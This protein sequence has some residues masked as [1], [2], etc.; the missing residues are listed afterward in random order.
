MYLK[1]VLIS[2]SALCVQ[3]LYSV[4]SI[5]LFKGT[6]HNHSPGPCKYVLGVENG[7]EDVHTLSNGLTFISSGFKLDNPDVPSMAGRILLY[8]M[9]NPDEKGAIDLEL[10]G[11]DRAGFV[12]HGISAWEDKT[13][14]IT[15]FIV[16]HHKQKERIESFLYQPEKKSLRHLKTYKD[17]SMKNLNDVLATSNKTFYFTNWSNSRSFWPNTL[18]TF[19]LLPW[20][21]V[22][23]HDGEIYRLVAEDLVMANGL[24]MSL[25]GKYVYVACSIT[26]DLKVFRR[27]ADNSLTFHQEHFVDSFVD[28]PTVDKNGD[29]WI[30]CHPNFREI[31]T[32]MLNPVNKSPSQVIKL[33]MQDGLVKS[34][35]EAYANDGTMLSASAVASFYNNRILI[36]SLW[37][38]LL[39]CDVVYV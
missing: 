25:D 14:E 8:D 28:N 6:V 15:I 3:H 16:N 1:I 35:K 21:N 31:W 13:G 30:G 33:E 39:I 38:K 34:M 2:L 18:E 36:G 26:K 23:Y 37:E 9:S 4:V 29:V 5:F 24:A 12:P 11:F 20:T 7:A 10:E 27:E 19:L 22:Y 32:Y 17:G